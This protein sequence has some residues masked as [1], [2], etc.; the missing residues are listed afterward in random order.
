MNVGSLTGQVRRG[1]SRSLGNL[2]EMTAVATVWL[3]KQ[4]YDGAQIPSSMSNCD[5]LSTS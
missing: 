5:T 4:P 1:F 3:S 2:L